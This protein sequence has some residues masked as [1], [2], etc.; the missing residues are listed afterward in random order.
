MIVLQRFTIEDSCMY[1]PDRPMRLEYEMVARL[2]P[3]EYEKRMNRGY[4]KFG[5][6][7]FHPNCAS[8]QECRPIRIPVDRFE[9][10]R[11]MRRALKRN[12]DLIVRFAEPTLDGERLALYNRYHRAQ[13]AEKE[14]PDDSKDAEEYTFSFLVSDVPLVEISV[15]E[16]VEGAEV[17]RAIVLTE[18][19]PKVV[20]GI[21]HYYEPTLKNR[22]IGVFAMLQTLELARKLQKPYAYFG[23]FVAGSASMAYKAQFHPSELLGTD[24]VWREIPYKGETEADTP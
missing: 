18:I 21:Y 23:Y 4:R 12:A 17:L 24:G 1:L 11:R 9:P 16:T 19:T 5:P 2:S 13:A 22:S 20:S 10:S 15:W 7:L 3:Q 6:L 14:W 8:C